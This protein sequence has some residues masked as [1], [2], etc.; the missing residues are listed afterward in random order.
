MSTTVT[1]IHW[2]RDSQQ[3]LHVIYYISTTENTTY[4]SPLCFSNVPVLIIHLQK[5]WETREAKEEIANLFH[6][7]V[8]IATLD[9][10]PSGRRLSA[11]FQTPT[12]KMDI[13]THTLIYSIRV[14]FSAVETFSRTSVLFTCTFSFLILVVWRLSKARMLSNRVYLCGWSG[15]CDFVS[16]H[17][18]ATFYLD[19]LVYK[20]IQTTPMYVHTY[21]YV[22]TWTEKFC[23][24][25]KNE[26]LIYIHM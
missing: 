26:F 25:A 2:L 5:D 16:S 3:L 13:S 23:N 1:Y 17:R 8:S 4:E 21:V 10:F 9:V 20:P 15:L 19:V 14:D 22:C 11:S 18:S 12:L 7:W 24:F 6:Y